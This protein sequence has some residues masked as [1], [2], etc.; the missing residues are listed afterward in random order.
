[1]DILIDLSPVLQATFSQVGAELGTAQPQLLH[2]F[3]EIGLS[4][5]GITQSQV[6]VDNFKPHY[7]LPFLNGM[8]AHAH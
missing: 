6:K 7:I 3:L 1:M 2:F 5:S 4:P 8:V